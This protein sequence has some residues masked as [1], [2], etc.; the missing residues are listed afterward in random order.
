M[1]KTWNQNFLLRSGSAALAKS[2]LFLA[3]QERIPNSHRIP[4]L[5]NWKMQSTDSGG[6]VDRQEVCKEKRQSS[7]VR[8]GGIPKGLP[9][10]WLGLRFLSIYSRTCSISML[11]RC[12]ESSIPVGCACNILIC[13]AHLNHRDCEFFLVFI[14]SSFWSALLFLLS[15]F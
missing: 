7:H 11:I 1:A 4:C 12:A 10:K 3:Q 14:V 15:S 13:C 6:W 5:M 9:E 8:P 2:Q